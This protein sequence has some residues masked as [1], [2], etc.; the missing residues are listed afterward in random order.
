[1]E[2]I[3]QKLSPESQQKITEIG[4][5]IQRGERLTNRE[6]RIIEKI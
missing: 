6:K 5:K 3:L 1:M 2:W 4:K